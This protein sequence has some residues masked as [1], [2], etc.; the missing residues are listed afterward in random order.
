MSYR[1]NTTENYHAHELD[2]LGW[3]LTVCNALYP[4]NSPCR[5]VLKNKA[6]LGVNLYHFLEKHI[7]FENIRN[8]LEIGGGMGY[9]SLDFLKLNSNLRAMLLDISPYL[10]GRQKRTLGKYDGRFEQADALKKD[11]DFFSRFDLVIM[12]ENLGDLPA[13]IPSDDN[14]TIPSQELIYYQNKAERLSRKYN[15]RFDAEEVINIGALSLLEKIC[16][17]GVRYIYLSEHS[18]EAV[19][20]ENLHELIH[21]ASAGFPEKISLKGHDEYTIKFSH[22]QKMAQLL[23]YKVLRGTLADILPLEFN[24]KLISTLRMKATATDEQ[25]IIRQFVYDL[26]KY[27]YL[28]LKT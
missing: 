20:P 6:S 7:S 23:G 10:V 26:Y 2:T 19:A 14:K 17:A 25:E 3:E 22:L 5:S 24:E 18:C 28:F 15:L 8:Y 16:R 27:E 11:E 13:L 4:E 21:I 9:L 1:L 12:N